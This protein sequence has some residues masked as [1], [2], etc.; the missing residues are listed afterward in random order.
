MRV[1]AAWRIASPLAL[2]LA[3][4]ATSCVV[5][6]GI[7]ISP[8]EAV[9]L[10]SA[11]SRTVALTQRI[12]ARYGLNPYTDP[13]QSQE[14]F[15]LCMAHESY[16]LCVKSTDREVQFRIYEASRRFTTLADSLNRELTDSLRRMFGPARVRACEWRLERPPNPSGCRRTR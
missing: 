13:Y 5:E 12:G 6:R 1:R 16:F 14:H 2:G 3:C 10:D 4:L 9:P 15:A 7:R 11:L 8:P